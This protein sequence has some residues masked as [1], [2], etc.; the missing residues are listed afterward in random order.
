MQGNAEKT[1]KL[2]RGGWLEAPWYLTGGNQALSKIPLDERGDMRISWRSKPGSFISISAAE[3]L[4]GRARSSLPADLM[5]GAW[6]LV[7]S[8]AFSLKDTIATPFGGAQAGMQAHAQMITAL[9]D[10][11][12]EER[13]V[14]KEC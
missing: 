7:G 11:R 10:G 14:G 5:A 8:S 9:I 12:S 1:L 13:R 6:V 3:I 4:S 2:Q